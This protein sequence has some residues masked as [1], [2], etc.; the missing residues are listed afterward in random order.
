M[1]FDQGS[2]TFRVCRLPQNLPEDAL[3]AFQKKALKNV[4]DVGE[5][6]LFGWVSGRN[7][8]ESTIDENTAMVGENYLHLCLCQAQRKVPS[9]L[10]KAKVKMAE[11]L[12]QAELQADRL[13]RNERKKIKED[14]AKE[15]LPHMPPSLGGVWFVID[16]NEQLLYVTAASQ[17]PLELFLGLFS[18]TI[19]FEP[20]P[21]TPASLAE[22]LLDGGSADDVPQLNFSPELGD[23]AAGGS[24]G[25]NFLTWLWFWLDQN[26]GVLPPSKLGEFSLMLDGPLTFVSENSSAQELVVRKGRPT[27][28]PDSMIALVTGKK[29][30]SAKLLMAREKQQWSFTLDADEFVFRSMKLPEGESLD[31][32]SYFDERMTLTY[33]FQKVFFELFRKFLS[34]VKDDARRKATE[35]KAK[36]WV[37]SLAD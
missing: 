22:E 6:P 9:S 10:L 34:E 27:V 16:R 3:K 28:S 33:E 37:E 15:L 18:Q 25:Q 20:V 11:L 35:A 13:P 29:L 26:G 21:V 24:L 31:A 7:L 12:K 5:E 19:G 14:V 30:K 2:F 4:D 17:K 36:K 8:L 32:V 1:P 23:E